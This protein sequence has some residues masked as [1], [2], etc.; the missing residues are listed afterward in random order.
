MPIFDGCVEEIERAYD[1]LGYDLGWRF[2]SVS[3]A[4]L[5]GQ[6]KIAF[7]TLNPGGNQ[8]PV[9]HPTASCENGPS[10]LVERWRGKPPGQAP[11][12]VQVQKLFQG[13]ANQMGFQAG[14]EGLMERS[15]IGHYIPFRS[16]RFEDLPHQEEGIAV[17]RLVW[18]R[19]LRHVRP[20]LVICLGR[21]VQ[22]E[23]RILLHHELNGIQRNTQSLPSGWGDMEI[24]I[25][26]YE[27][28]GQVMRLLYLP[29]LSTFKLFSRDNCKDPMNA[30]LGAATEG[31]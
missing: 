28:S 5:E 19:L 31:F 23:L 4:V 9:D 21:K 22:S 17:G 3:R 10:Y 2:L 20:R 8:I 7:V 12:Q 26:T 29:H 18:G 30:V 27:S 13:L 6:V 24:D 16:P 11:L 1:Q 14:S 25:D 15:L